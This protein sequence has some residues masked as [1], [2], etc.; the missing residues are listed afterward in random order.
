MQENVL[1]LDVAV[2]NLTPVRVFKRISNF[3]GNADCERNGELAFARQQSPKSLALDVRHHVVEQPL[4]ASR[5]EQRQNV[6]MLKIRGELYLLQE[7]IGAEYGGEFGM[8]QLD[9]DFAMVLDV[10]G[11]VDR[12]H[13]ARAELALDPVTVGEMRCQSL[14][15]RRGQVYFRKEATWKMGIMTA[16]AS[17]S[18]LQ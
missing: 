11:E 18:R 5:I 12:R 9:R 15:N 13:S 14:Q 16:T 6:R 1:R 4:R 7:A 3:S 8:Q 2:N 17:P 10:F